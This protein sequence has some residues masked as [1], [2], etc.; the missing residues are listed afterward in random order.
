MYTAI[1]IS[2]MITGI[3]L[4]SALFSRMKNPLP[5]KIAGKIQRTATCALLFFMGI[6]LGGNGT[7][8]R[9]IRQIGIKGALFAVVTISASVLS[10]YIVSKLV[11]VK[12]TA[13]DPES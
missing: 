4:G 12:K 7:F 2:L 1:I 5:L 10:V 11:F 13:D 9:D 8:W 6:W 3:I